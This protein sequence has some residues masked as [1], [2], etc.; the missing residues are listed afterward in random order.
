M[1]ICVLTTEDKNSAG[2]KGQWLCAYKPVQS[3]RDKSFTWYYA[4]STTSHSVLSSSKFED[5]TDKKNLQ[6]CSE[7]LT[8]ENDTIQKQT[9]VT[10]SPCKTNKKTSDVFQA[11][12]QRI[13]CLQKEL[14]KISS[15][16]G[17][18]KN[19][20]LANLDAFHHHFYFCMKVSEGLCP[21]HYVNLHKNSHRLDKDCRPFRSERD[22]AFVYK[23]PVAVGL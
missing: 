18:K 4:G 20:A 19:E 23:T 11:V 21:R 8:D 1:L 16:L 14:F 2:C 12:I 6:N 5:K 13:K 22:G 3:I 15:L 10:K 17:K 7:T 9:T